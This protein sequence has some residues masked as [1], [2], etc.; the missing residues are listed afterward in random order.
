MHRGGGGLVAQDLKAYS[1]IGLVV[2][3]ERKESGSLDPPTG[4]PHVHPYP[5]H[6]Q[7]S[8]AANPIRTPGHIFALLHAHATCFLFNVCRATCMNSSNRPDCP[9]LTDAFNSR[10]LRA[11]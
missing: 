9:P 10:L 6:S 5:V 3:A 11:G 2:T 4:T 7:E 1:M 8:S